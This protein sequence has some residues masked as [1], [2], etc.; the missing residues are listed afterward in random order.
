MIRNIY[1]INWF[2]DVLSPYILYADYNN[3]M[4][5]VCLV[6]G[7]PHKIQAMKEHIN[8]KRVILTFVEDEGEDVMDFINKKCYK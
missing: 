2:N 4:H 6:S 8:N 5:F 7:P 1:Y 3:F